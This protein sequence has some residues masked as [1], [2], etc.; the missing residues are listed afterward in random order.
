M[1]DRNEIMP[2]IPIILPSRIEKKGETEKGTKLECVVI[3]MD[4]FHAAI[5]A[6]TGVTQSVTGIAV[7]C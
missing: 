5:N 7:K 3:S 4:L 6:T 1:G 2:R